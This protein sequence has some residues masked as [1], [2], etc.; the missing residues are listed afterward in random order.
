MLEFLRF[1]PGDV[2]QL[3][4][5]GADLA[6]TAQCD[7][8]SVEYGDV[9]IDKDTPFQAGTSTRDDQKTVPSILLSSAFA[10]PEKTAIGVRSSHPLVTPEMEAGVRQVTLAWGANR[11]TLVTGPLGKPFAALRSCTD[12]LVTSWGLDPA[13]QNAL[14]HDAR[15]ANVPAMV[16]SIQAV[17]P[18]TLAARGKQGRVNFL[19]LVDE[20]GAVTQCRTMQSYNVRAFDDLA[21]NVVRK[22][23]FEPALDK[24]GKPVASYYVETVG[25]VLG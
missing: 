4:I 11:L 13:V 1:R 17:Y 23:R 20:Q 12:D 16:R 21:C 10:Q 6:G 8:V 9:F 24:D 25:Y 18:K 15:P 2:F 22:T 5:D 19:A 3:S 14:S 7:K